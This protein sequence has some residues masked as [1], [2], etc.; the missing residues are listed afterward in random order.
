VADAPARPTR[1]AFTLIE[2]IVAIVI[3]A[4]VATAITSS[5]SQLGRARE[6]ARLRMTACRRATDALEAIRRDV[7]STLRSSDLFNTRFR[8][9]P[10]SV[11]SEVGELD[12]D[13]ML[14]FDESLRPTRP[15]DYSGE[16]QEYE[17]QYRIEA[18]ADGTALWRRRDAVP[19]QYEDAG[20][21]AAPV[22]EGV[23]S[24]RFEAYD[25]N[26]WR[27]A[28][29]SDVDGLPWSVRAT[30]TAS[31]VKLGS[32]PFEDAKSMVT[33]RTEIPIDRVEPPKAAPAPD[34]AGQD[35]TGSG[36]TPPADVSGTGDTGTAAGGGATGA[37]D[38]GRGGKGGPSGPG[39]PGGRGGKG[40]G[41]QMQGAGGFRG[42]GAVPF[43]PPSRG[44]GSGGGR[45]GG[46]GGG[47]SRPGPQ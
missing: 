43:T 5:L 6:V 37:G 24:V 35:A 13:Q 46:G 36:T 10:E 29:D 7:Q 27:Q 21:I 14:L 25:G 47:G 40:D 4:M 32:N 1:R 15:L 17:T 28:W 30:V 31:G 3:A 42:G 23:V 20:G 22:G 44:G 41:S 18:D 39:G 45:T 12:R 33:L 16:G 9:A 11:R 19:D 2:L 38:G 34:A 8:L 26:T